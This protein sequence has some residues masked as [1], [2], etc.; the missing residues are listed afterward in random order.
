[1][2]TSIRIAVAEQNTKDGGGKSSGTTLSIDEL[3]Y[4]M[5]SSGAFLFFSDTAGFGLASLLVD[6]RLTSASSTASF[7]VVTCYADGTCVDGT[8]T[9]SASWIGQGDVQHDV[10]NF[11]F[12]KG[13][14]S[15]NSHFNGL[16]RSA[17]ATATV[18]GSDL[19]ASVFADMFNA[20]S[21]L[22]YICHMC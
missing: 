21:G 16:T 3:S 9:V 22:V 13:P 19:G 6:S 20:K 14:L 12:S 15:G 10:T 18:N 5:D 8:V 7:P 1:V 11:H 17:S 4:G 2:C